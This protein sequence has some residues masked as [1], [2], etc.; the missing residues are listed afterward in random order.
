[1]QNIISSVIILLAGCNVPIA[2]DGMFVVAGD[3][4]SRSDE[5]CEVQIITNGE[6]DARDY[7][8]RSVS[9]KFKE[10]FSVSPQSGIYTIK[11]LCNKIVI[12]EKRV[13]YPSDTGVGGVVQIEGIESA[14]NET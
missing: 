9:G 1:M 5:S 10:D 13:K 3:I 4:S 2:S 12:A 8:I 14:T 11:L 7:N 6:R